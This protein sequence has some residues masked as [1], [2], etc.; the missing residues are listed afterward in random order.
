MNFKKLTYLCMQRLTN[1]PYIEEDFDAL[2]NYQL[3]SKVVEYLN[4]VIKNSNEQNKVITEYTNAFVE[5]KNYVD[6][7]FENLD[8]Q[9]E[10]NNK[11][12]EMA[13]DGTLTNLIKNYVDPIYEA[14][15]EQI[16]DD[17]QSFKTSTNNRLTEMEN[18]IS[19][20]ASGSPLV[21]SSTSDMTDTSKIYVN[22]TDGYW[23]YYNGTAWTQGG[24]YQSTG[25]SSDDYVITD[26]QKA[27]NIEI[28]ESPTETGKFINVV[29]TPVNYQNPTVSQSGYDYYLISCSKDDVFTITGQGGDPARL[30]CFIDTDGN[31]LS[32]SLGNVTASNLSIKAPLNTAYLI[33]NKIG[34]C[35]I[36]KGY[37]VDNRLESLPYI[38]N[39]FEYKANSG[40]SIGEE[41]NYTT[42]NVGMYEMINKRPNSSL[43]SSNYNTYSLEG[44]QEIY[45][46]GRTGGDGANY[47]LIL[48][49]DKNETSLLKYGS[50]NLTTYTDVYLKAPKGTVKAYVNGSSG[51]TISVK[52]ANPF[53]MTLKEVYESTSTNFLPEELLYKRLGNKQ[54]GVFEKP[55]I[56]ISSDDGLSELIT[57]TIPNILEKVHTDTGIYIPFTFALMSSSYVLQETSRVNTI[58]D[59]I[60]NKNC[61]IAYHG[62]NSYTAYTKDELISFLD[63]EKTFFNNLNLNPKGI[64]YPNH[65]RNDMVMTICGSREGVACA[66]GAYDSSKVYSSPRKNM[67]GLYRTS[68]LTMSLDDAKDY[69]DYAYSH[70]YLICFFFHDNNIAS[71]TGATARIVSIIE[72]AIT[73]GMNFTTIGDIPNLI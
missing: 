49:V 70:N 64:V 3:L 14:F 29:Q 65:A 16:N 5:L 26:L 30:W 37:D 59:M 15:E 42:H 73:K 19:S 24:V 58:K 71:T 11:L 2:T 44:G 50:S 6:S 68:L 61:S 8:V 69:I 9:E 25:V 63:N 45:V 56:C 23:Y 17:V 41:I 21:A 35:Y 48:F 28:I 12:D 18:E 54:V 52:R 38:E 36:W 20:V 22:T 32:R 4:E 46:S 33:V 39:S 13:N 53:N 51:A 57:N 66:G 40:T 43:T 34:T 1:F 27:L 47:S 62:A 72:Y 7:Y 55:Y 10:I 31:V 67:Y 60:N